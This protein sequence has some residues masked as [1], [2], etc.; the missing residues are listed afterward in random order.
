M[1]VQYNAPPILLLLLLFHACMHTYMNICKGPYIHKWMYTWTAPVATIPCMYAFIHTYMN[2]C[3][4]PYIHAW[5]YTWTDLWVA[6]NV[7]CFENVTVWMC[8]CV[9]LF[10]CMYVCMYVCTK[11]LPYLCMY[12]CVYK[13]TCM[14][15]CVCIYISNTSNT[16]M[17]AAAAYNSRLQCLRQN[18]KPA[19]VC[20]CVQMDTDCVWQ[21]NW[22]CVYA[23]HQSGPQCST[24]LWLCPRAGSQELVCLAQVQGHCRC[25]L[26]FDSTKP[27][28]YV[29]M[30]VCTFV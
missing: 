23:T 18:K 19:Y 7:R 5:M 21:A 20:M 28:M 11:L 26:D 29:S 1:D 27:S 4:W 17:H 13:K 8:V 10:V 25:F 16:H 12:A 22:G 30:Y 3:I 24:L 6:F 9:C 14:H 2:I 15:L